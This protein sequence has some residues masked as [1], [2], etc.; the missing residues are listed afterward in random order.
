M[1]S[2][3]STPNEKSFNMEKFKIFRADHS[4]TTLKTKEQ[5]QST[6]DENSSEES[7]KVNYLFNGKKLFSRHYNNYVKF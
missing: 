1:L 3:L 6:E 5:F 4:A 2:Y 7:V